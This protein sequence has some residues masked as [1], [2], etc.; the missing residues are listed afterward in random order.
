ME[1][2]LQQ[3]FQQEHINLEGIRTIAQAGAQIRMSSFAISC[4]CTEKCRVVLFYKNGYATGFVFVKNEN[5][6]LFNYTIHTKSW[7]ISLDDFMETVDYHNKL[8]KIIE[9][10]VIH[11]IYTNSS[12]KVFKLF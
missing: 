11:P 3:L 12:P 10:S 4:N 5:K 6:K 1:N 2:K 9:I 7:K 8:D